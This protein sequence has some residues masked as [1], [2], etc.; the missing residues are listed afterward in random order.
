MKMYLQ[1]IFLTIAVAMSLVIGNSSALLADAF[2]YEGF[3]YDAGTLTGNNGGTGW[4]DPWSPNASHAAADVSVGSSNYTDTNG[5]SLVTSGNKATFSSA[6]S[7]PSGLRAF[8]L[9]GAPAGLVENG[10]LGKDGTSVWMSFLWAG[11]S[12][13]AQMGRYFTL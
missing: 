11:G 4:V 7:N 10:K 5:N 9:S 13:R 2:V 3:D 8:D 12:G 6:V 1:R